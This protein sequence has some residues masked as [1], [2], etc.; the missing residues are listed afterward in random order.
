MA[1]ICPFFDPI[2][3]L[4]IQVRD[5]GER[6]GADVYLHLRL[7]FTRRSHH[8]RQ[9]LPNNFPGLDGHHALAA[10]FDSKANNG[11][12]YDNAPGN[13]SDLLP[14]LHQSSIGKPLS[15]AR[16]PPNHSTES[17]GPRFLWRARTSG[18]FWGYQQWHTGITQ[19]VQQPVSEAL[20]IG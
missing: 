18:I 13:E 10:L 2:A 5:L 4:D 9:I 6:V 16:P 11:E 14:V 19:R 8:R 1:S 17:D 3:F 7:N 20:P 15:G 12:Q